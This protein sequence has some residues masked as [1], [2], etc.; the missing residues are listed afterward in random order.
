MIDP[1]AGSRISNLD[2]VRAFAALTVFVFHFSIRVVERP[3]GAPLDPTLV[4]F[5]QGMTGVS[6]FMVLSGYLFAKLTEGRRIAYGPFVLRRV[7]RLAPLLVF[8]MIVAPFAYG[9]DFGTAIGDAVLGFVLPT[10]PNGGWSVAVELHFYL[11]FPVLVAL[12]GRRIRTA[13]LIAIAGMILIRA[14]LLWGDQPL[15]DL[16]HYTLVGRADQFLIGI[17]VQ[18]TAGLMRGRHGVAAIATV[19]LLLGL[20]FQLLTGRF[21]VAKPALLVWYPFEG[22]VYAL[23]IAWYDRSFTFADRGLSKAAAAF[24]RW[25]Y[26]FYLLHLFF[27]VPFI[28]L[29][30]ARFGRIP[31]MDAGMLWAVATL[32]FFIVVSA[33]GYV[34][35]ERPFLKVGGSYLRPAGDAGSSGQGR[36]EGRGTV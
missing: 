34:V 10:W 4:F 18:R 5:G 15:R 20:D 19:L 8:V 12:A 33:L 27:V 32:P 21:Q 25:S 28:A 2:H 31:S 11:L 26:S 3:D 6:I 36:V 35:F 23:L 14:A 29:I 7:V 30:E 22:A 24:G 17:I 13:C 1:P 9:F 16:S